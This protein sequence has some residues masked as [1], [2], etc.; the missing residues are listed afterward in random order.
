MIGG[1]EAKLCFPDQF[2][3][4]DGKAS[5]W[6]F[7]KMMEEAE[8]ILKKLKNCPKCGKPV[9]GFEDGKN[10]GPGGDKDKKD[11]KGGLKP[12]E[13]N[14]PGGSGLKPNEDNKP[15]GKGEDKYCN[16]GGGIG[17]LLDDHSGWLSDE[18]RKVADM[19]SL[20]RKIEKNTADMIRESATTF[21]ARGTLPSGFE[22]LIGE[23]LNPPQLPYHQIVRKLVKGT[24][25]SKFQSCSTRINRKRTYAFVI[26]RENFPEISP[27]PGKKRDFTFSIGILLDT[28]GSMSKDD[29][30][31]GLSG[32]KNLIENDKNTL[33]TVIENDATIHA[34]YE[35]KKVKDIQH[36]IHG[37]GGTTLGPGLFRFKELSPDIVLCFT[38]GFV[39][40]INGYSRASL[41]RKILWI[42]TP[43][44]SANNLDRYG[45][46]IKLPKK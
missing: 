28:S 18:I 41:P 16:C 23:L 37:R 32:I 27:F 2:K 36:N 39:E 10:Q 43:D 3:L 45:Y 6:Y 44:G 40:N 24:R 17:E 30:I 34:E 25:L 46:V 42:L 19:Q 33:V 15:G 35:I 8:E 29:I 13:D 12:N 14:K 22:E 7:E 1:R 11:G 26:G 38:D 9:R 5:E 31:E 20:A 4:P 21:R